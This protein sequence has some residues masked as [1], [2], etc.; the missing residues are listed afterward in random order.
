MAGSH[1]TICSI[2]LLSYPMIHELLIWTH[3]KST[4]ESYHTNC[5]VSTGLNRTYRRI[6]GVI[7]AQRQAAWCIMAVR[8]E[9]QELLIKVEKNLLTQFLHGNESFN[10]KA[11]RIILESR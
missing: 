10:N 3:C 8:P 4:K 6:S 5:T 1:G 7:F 11:R 9:L 2:Q